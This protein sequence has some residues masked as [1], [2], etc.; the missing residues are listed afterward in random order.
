MG[1]LWFGGNIYTMEKE[2]TAIEAVYTEEGVIKAVGTYEKLYHTYAASI[3]QVENL[4]GKTMLPGLVDSHLHIIGHGEKL[5]RLDLSQMKSASEVVEALSNRT[6]NLSEGEWLIGEGWNENQWEDASIIHKEVLDKISP[7]N[8]MMLSR[9]CRHAILANT[10]AMELA[11]VTEESPDPQG[12]IIV[13]D[14]V[15][16]TTGYFLDTAQELI[17]N[18]M[19][20]VSQDYLEQVINIATDDLMSKGLVGG[21]SEDLN[22]YGGFHK[23]FGAF[24]NA[25]DGKARKFK[26][27]LL[28]HHEV[29]SDMVDEGLGY[30]EGTEYV[31][32]GAVKIFSDGALGGRTAWLTEE[33]ADEKGNYGVAIHNEET[34]E[35]IVK[36]ARRHG[37]PIAVHAI[38]DQA[39]DAITGIIKKHPL[40]NGARDRIIHGQILNEHS[41]KMLKE[42]P[43]V[44]DIQ[45]SFVSSDF[46][47]VLDR[48]GDK[49]LGLYYAWKTLLDEG[50]KCAGGSDAPIEEVSPLLGIEAAVTR[51]SQIDNQVYRPEERLSVFEAVTLYTSGSAYVINQEETRGKIAP[52]FSADFTV[53]EEDIFQVQ[54]ETI[55]EINVAMTVI[56]GNIVYKNAPSPL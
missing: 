46:P 19:P 29:M 50:V 36:E 37:L 8:P 14:D 3:E 44:V 5:L 33:Y 4:Q 30:L 41:L 48:I 13:R 38:G 10:K 42:L 45:P 53:L 7:H 22:Y 52:G 43:V 35:H 18:A 47:W 11:G 1:V 32:L 28:V 9:V 55:H 25:I 2:G 54:P 31:E 49:R 17:K 12:G 20:S 21:H 27:H 24:K 40:S 39:V 51:K 26:A 56:D 16:E 34:L 23:T 15:G 6:A